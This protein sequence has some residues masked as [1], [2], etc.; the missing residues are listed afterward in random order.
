MK[1]VYTGYSDKAN[2]LLIITDKDWD[3]FCQSQGGKHR[4]IDGQNLLV[5]DDFINDEE[6]LRDSVENSEYR[7][8]VIALC[9]DEYRE[10]Y[11][12]TNAVCW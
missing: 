4:L 11:N 5:L 10:D 3:E 9:R 7:W 12:L 2:G 6:S 8:G 1:Y